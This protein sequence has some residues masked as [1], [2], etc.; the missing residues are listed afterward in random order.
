MSPARFWPCQGDNTDSCRSET[1]AESHASYSTLISTTSHATHDSSFSYSHP[2]PRYAA[3]PSYTSAGGGGLE[4][5][6]SGGYGRPQ[7]RP[8]TFSGSSAGSF[9]PSMGGGAGY[10]RSLSPQDRSPGQAHSRQQLPPLIHPR[11]RHLLSH[12]TGNGNGNG[13]GLG[14]GQGSRSSS[15]SRA[16]AAERIAENE[17]SGQSAQ[18]PAMPS[19]HVSSASPSR[20][21]PS[22]S[23]QTAKQEAGRRDSAVDLRSQNREK[24]H[25]DRVKRR[26]AREARRVLRRAERESKST[27]GGDRYDTVMRRMLRWAGRRGW[28]WYGMLLMGMWPVDLHR[29]LVLVWGK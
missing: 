11:P 9:S 29:V 22:S 5:G 6:S 19:I 26:A 16:P 15:F 24:R 21:R 14:S 20:R 18:A 3:A 12:G 25:A 8:R 7:L 1:D 13:D 28:G 23:T 10:G 4:A 27:L 17:H 2:H